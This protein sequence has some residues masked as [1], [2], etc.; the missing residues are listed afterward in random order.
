MVTKDTVDES[1]YNLQQRKAEMNAAIME[2]PDSAEWFKKAQ[3]SDMECILQ[4]ALDQF[5]SSSFGKKL[6]VAAAP[7]APTL[8]LDRDVG[9]EVI[10][11]DVADDGDDDVSRS[12]VKLDPPR[13]AR[14]G[15]YM[16][17]N[18]MAGQVTAKPVL[19]NNNVVLE[20]EKVCEKPSTTQTEISI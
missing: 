10:N 9:E 8:A 14:E 13:T 3:V 1:I 11:L 15:E 5:R 7:V 17:E 16:K 20:E 12:H 19:D 18:V 4:T 2:N 6:A